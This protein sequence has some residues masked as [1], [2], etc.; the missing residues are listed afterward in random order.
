MKKI[1][2]NTWK[3]A[4]H[5]HFFKNFD[6]PFHSLTFKVDATRAFQNAKSAKKSFFNFYVHSCLRAVNQLDGFKYRIKNGEVYLCEQVNVSATMPKGDGT[7]RFSYVEYHPDAKVFY[8]NMEAEKERIKHQE[9]L[10]PDRNDDEVIHFSALPWIH[11]TALTHARDYSIR[12]SVP[13]ISVGGLV[14][15]N[16]RMLLPVSVTIHHALADGYDIGLFK[17]AFQDFLNE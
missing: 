8:Q 7:F 3:R 6:E 12:D 2:I 9:A 13:K 1:D 14:E 16:D 5:F 15:E 4:V 17:D 10:F 11:F